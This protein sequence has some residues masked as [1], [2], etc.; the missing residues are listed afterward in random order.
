MIVTDGLERTAWDTP[1]S[2]RILLLKPSSEAGVLGAERA[3]K[4]HNPS[5]PRSLE[6]GAAWATYA[7]SCGNI[8]GL[9]K[10]L[11]LDCFT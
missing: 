9:F 1:S 4:V 7:G 11:G 3:G 2:A 6:Q 10:L 5:E 8:F